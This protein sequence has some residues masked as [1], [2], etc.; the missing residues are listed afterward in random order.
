LIDELIIK[1]TKELQMLGGFWLVATVL[2]WL[3]W[4]EYPE[5]FDL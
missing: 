4:L 1:K 2:T 5:K 3:L